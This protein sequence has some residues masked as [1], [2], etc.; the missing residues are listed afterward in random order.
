MKPAN[1]ILTINNYIY[2][3]GICQSS[4]GVFPSSNLGGSDHRPPTT[5]NRPPLTFSPSDVL[6]FWGSDLWLSWSDPGIMVLQ[7]L[8]CILNCP[9]SPKDDVYPPLLLISTTS[10]GNTRSGPFFKV[11][12]CQNCKFF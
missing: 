6:Q 11:V 8:V 10:F 12:P 2:L 7:L 5:D 3:D 4:K 1:R 9:G